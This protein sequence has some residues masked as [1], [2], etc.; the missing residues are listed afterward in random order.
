MKQ[1]ISLSTVVSRSPWVVD[2]ELLH[3]ENMFHGVMVEQ[4]LMR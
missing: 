1:M 3:V 2:V 4:W